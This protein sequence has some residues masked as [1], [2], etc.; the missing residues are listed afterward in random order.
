MNNEAFQKAIREDPLTASILTEHNL[1]PTLFSKVALVIDDSVK[2]TI[3]NEEYP[4][5]RVGK[6]IV[7]GL[8]DIGELTHLIA[9]SIQ[10]A[11]VKQPIVLSYKKLISNLDTKAKQVFSQKR[12]IEA[13]NQFQTLYETAFVDKTAANNYLASLYR[14]AKKVELHKLEFTSDQV[15]ILNMIRKTGLALNEKVFLVGGVL[16]D[17]LL[18]IP[19]NDLDF[20]VVTKDLD[21]FVEHLSQTNHLRTPV[22]LERTQAYTLR[23]GTTDIDII[24]ARRVY[25]PLQQDKNPSLDEDD[26]WSLAYDDVFR[27]D[28]TINSLIYDLANNEIKDPTKRGF[29]DLSKGVINTIIDPFVKYRINA[30]DMIRALRFAAIYDFELGPEM[31]NAMKANAHRLLMRNEGGEFSERRFS[32][33]LRKAAATVDSW[34]KMKSLLAESGAIDYL[35]DL[36][37]K[38]DEDRKLI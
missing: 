31:I 23:I 19:N 17:K 30:P 33:E 36:I 6:T 12:T 7:E 22:R 37:E 16:R 21:K 15:T 18:G 28:L 27:R 14:E 34:L 38:V 9:H 3:A 1:S 20:M 35:G 24:D 5:I 11:S 13:L 32:R 8:E 2:I 29:E 4:I 26:D 10:D 25:T